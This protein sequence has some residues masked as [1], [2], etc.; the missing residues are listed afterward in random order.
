MQTSIITTTVSIEG[1]NGMISS[2]QCKSPCSTI[3]TVIIYVAHLSLYPLY[4]H[5]YI[6]MYHEQHIVDGM[7]IYV[8]IVCVCV[9]I[10]NAI[11]N[12]SHLLMNLMLSQLELEAD[13]MYNF[14]PFDLRM[15]QV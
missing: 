4:T 11:Y 6:Y 14:I 8:C 10:G 3:S 9:Q 2:K 12:V 13:Q 1:T 15:G 5:V 7:I